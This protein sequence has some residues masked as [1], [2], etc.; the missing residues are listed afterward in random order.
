[1]DRTWALGLMIFG[2][3]GLWLDLEWREYRYRK[4]QERRQA[5]DEQDGQ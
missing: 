5:G 1:M 3:L 4:E 2:L